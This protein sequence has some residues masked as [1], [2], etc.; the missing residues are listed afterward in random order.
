MLMYGIFVR[1][2]FLILLL[3]EDMPLI[4][5]FVVCYSDFV[6][7]LSNYIYKLAKAMHA[8]SLCLRL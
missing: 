4:L 6:K 3:S 5:S 2:L 7:F 1:H 8:E